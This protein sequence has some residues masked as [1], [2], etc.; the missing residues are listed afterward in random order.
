MEM[1]LNIPYWHWHIPLQDA[2][3]VLFRLKSARAPM[4]HSDYPLGSLVG[5][6]GSE[7]VQLQRG[8]DILSSHVEPAKLLKAL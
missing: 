1:W 5:L 7:I 3:H 6:R 2:L 4:P 8:L